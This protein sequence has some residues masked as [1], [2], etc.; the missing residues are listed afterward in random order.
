MT[1]WILPTPKSNLLR[2][3]L[4]RPSREKCE[5]RRR[6]ESLVRRGSRKKGVPS[7]G[8]I[9]EL[10]TKRGT[11]GKRKKE[12]KKKKGIQISLAW[13]DLCFASAAGGIEMAKATAG[14]V[15]PPREFWPEAH[16]GVSRRVAARNLGPVEVRHG[17]R[18]PRGFCEA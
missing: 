13:A 16:I 18:I 11:D 5:G 9:A 6:R 17:T 1:L 3:S 10:P 14:I 12:K 2:A 7:R 4:L 8:R 15:W